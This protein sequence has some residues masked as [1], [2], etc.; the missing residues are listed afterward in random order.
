VPALSARSTGPEAGV[1]VRQGRIQVQVAVP[2][3]TA[4]RDA[5]VEFTWLGPRA[6]EPQPP[7][8]PSQVRWVVPAAQLA[9]GA[10]VPPASGPSRSG[11]WQMR[12]RAVAGNA[13]WSEAVAFDYV[14]PNE[15]RGNAWGHRANEIERQGLN[16][17]PLPP[18]E[19]TTPASAFQR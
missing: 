5:E 8:A 4:A 18:K 15:P 14:G 19:T 3:G 13:V 7:S 10:W 12:V 17:Q 9:Q 1:D 11:R 16:P 6:N 2:G